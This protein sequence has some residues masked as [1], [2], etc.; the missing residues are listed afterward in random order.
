M[1]NERA[2][3][4]DQDPIPD[5]GESEI[6][7]R[8]AL[9]DG[10]LAAAI[11]AVVAIAVLYTVS[12]RLELG[13]LDWDRGMVGVLA[14][15]IWALQTGLRQIS[16]AAER[17]L[18]TGI[19]LA[20]VTYLVAE[21][22]WLLF[23]DAYH[24]SAGN[25]FIEL[26]HLA[27]YLLILFAIEQ[28]PHEVIPAEQRQAWRARRDFELQGGFLFAIG[29][30]ASFVLIP[31]WVAAEDFAT[32]APSGCLYAALDLLV[33]V[34]T[35]QAYRDARSER[36][37]TLYRYLLVAEVAAWC[38]DLADLLEVFAVYE[39]LQA[40]Y[41]LWYLYPLLFAVAGRL[42][43]YLP[44]QDPT[45]QAAVAIEREPSRDPFSNILLVYTLMLPALH[46]LLQYFG[47]FDVATTRHRVPVILVYI[48]GF[49]MLIGRQQRFEANRSQAIEAQRRRGEEELRAAMRAAEA[50]SA[51]KSQ[52]L[53]N[54]SHEIRTPMTGIIGT[55]DLL[56][57]TPLSGQQRDL[58][59]TMQ[60]SG[61]TLL[62][63][64]DDILD[65]S[66]IESGH[67][68]LD[69]KAYDLQRTIRESLDLLI[70]VAGQKGLDLAYRVEQPIRERLVGDAIRTRQ[71]LVNLLNNAVKFT[72][73]G[74]I[75]VTLATRD[76]EDSLVEAHFTVTDT[77]IGIPTEH[78]GELF[79]PFSQVDPSMTRRHGGTGLGLAICRRLCELMG[80]RIWVESTLGEGSSF[81]FTVRGKVAIEKRA[82]AAG[83][84]AE[85]RG[86]DWRRSLKILVAEDNEV[87]QM[88]I[89]PMLARLG[90]QAELVA[91][92]EAVLE[93]AQRSSYD[94]ILM[95]VQMPKIDGLE[96]TRRMRRLF[97]GEGP[98]I[99]AMTAHAL[100][101]ERRRCLEAGM[102]DHFAKPFNLA[103]LKAAL[104]RLPSSRLTVRADPASG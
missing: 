27:Y 65:L 82:E 97:A 71:I 51:A 16:H 49:L 95:D 32:Y 10:P 94:V 70:P 55:A 40:Y 62:T 12:Q 91:D 25:L 99:I 59:E 46:L 86:E 48:V 102:D 29:L 92:G 11:F 31:L 8:R 7:V 43:H 13:L 20:F 63:V 87:T 9:G 90:Y 5:A 54:M 47:I 76:L 3:N 22:F 104:D 66:K 52:F 84:P 85:D 96:A 38:A 80:G 81:H 103:T 64:I 57:Q 45:R 17:R 53:A 1:W 6:S 58:L 56:L 15:S 39:D 36:W 79:K 75:R 100:P 26:C 77:G 30:L 93:A 24:T 89:L 2:S 34:R 98:Y 14:I 33:L 21:L 37:R 41:A 50:A 101:E 19:A 61:E 74:S 78:L 44:A 69:W 83:P 4:P 28:R 68:I 72:D 88:L 23:P 73:R 18:W 60:V 42:R 67:L 35:L